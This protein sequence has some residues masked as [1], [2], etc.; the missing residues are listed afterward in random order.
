MI[1]KPWHNIKPKRQKCLK[2]FA[3]KKRWS[4]NK[5]AKK[6]PKPRWCKFPDAQLG[7]MG[8]SSLYFGYTTKMRKD[9]CC[10]CDSSCNFDQEK[11]DREYYPKLAKEKLNEL[12]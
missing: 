5:F 1:P 12:S 4:W 11:F 2:A 7:V 10:G 9:K 8:C 6:Y 3:I